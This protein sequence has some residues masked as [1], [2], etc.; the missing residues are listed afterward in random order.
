MVALHYSPG[1]PR[2][3]RPTFTLIKPSLVYLHS[4]ARRLFTRTLSRIRPCLYEIAMFYNQAE[5]TKT[6][7]CDPVLRESQHQLSYY[8]TMINVRNSEIL[9]SFVLKRNQWASVALKSLHNSRLYFFLENLY[10][11]NQ[12]R[13]LCKVSIREHT[14]L[15]PIGTWNLQ[16]NT[17][18]NKGFVFADTV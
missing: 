2:K 10:T 15:V 12:T 7:L 13:N 16:L 17:P 3:I 1:N 4:N 18:G 14:S 9:L 6:I 5:F 11:L 8:S